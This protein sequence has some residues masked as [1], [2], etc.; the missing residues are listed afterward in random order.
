MAR[1]QSLGLCSREDAR[2][3]HHAACKTALVDILTDMSVADGHAAQL[4]NWVWRHLMGPPAV[5]SGEGKGGD[6]R[7]PIEE[8]VIQVLT[9]LYL[10]VAI[11]SREGQT[12]YSRW[13]ER[14]VLQPLRPAN[15]KVV[16]KALAFVC[17]AIASLDNDQ[18]VYGRVFLDGLPAS[19]RR[20]VATRHVE[21]AR[22]CGV[23][24]RGVFGLEPGQRLLNTDLFA[25]AR[26]VLAT[27][28]KQMLQDL[29]GKALTVGLD[30]GDGNVVVEW[31]GAGGV[32]H[33]AKIPELSL[34]SPEGTVRVAALR[35]IIQR[36]GPAARDFRSLLR[37]TA[38]RELSEDEVSAIFHENANGVAAF[39]THMKKAV[40]L[41][42]SIDV[43]DL[44]PQ[45]LSYFENFAGP[46][47]VME[48]PDVYFRD[49]LVPH[50]KVLLERNLRAGLDICCLGALR[51]DLTPGQWL[52]S[53]GDDAVWEALSSVDAEENPFSLLAALDI[54]MYRQ[55][56]SRFQGFAGEAVERLSEDGFRSRD[57]TDVYR[58]LQVVAD[59]VFNRINLLDSGSIRPGYWK[60]M[61][62]LM[63]ASVIVR[64]VIA[65]SSSMDIDAFEQWLQGATTAV[66]YFAGVV[67]ARTQPMLFFGR[68]T[69]YSLHS[70]ILGRLVALKSRHEKQGRALPRSESLEGALT[71][72]ND[73]EELLTLYFPGPLEGHQR[74]TE[75]FTAGAGIR[76]PDEGSGD[77]KRFLQDLAIVSHVFALDEAELNLAR[78]AV[79]M[80]AENYDAD[81]VET[82]TCLESASLV[83][84]ANRDVALADAIAD[85]MAAVVPRIDIEKDCPVTVAILLQAAAARGTPDEWC[86]WL[87]ERLARIASCLPLQPAESLHVY[88]S[89]L[90]ELRTVLPIHSWFQIRA[91]SIAAS[92][93]R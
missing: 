73:R 81:L 89:I 91:S 90:D 59:F 58:L 7:D 20:L 46:G 92:G 67:D 74:P 26:Q 37:E 42:P 49:V 39:Q 4:C 15:M 71:R 48:D 18:E 11:E 1:L 45:S 35:D 38:S 51:D 65:T 21:F 44:I 47:P 12:R 33:R 84:A 34:F 57:G 69:G 8:W 79:K 55:G 17:E 76:P 2:L 43:H 10:P 68:M 63:H 19:I 53:F 13:M 27:G 36:L 3:R 54:A 93:A 60:R 75:H 88:G 9:Y 87:E 77:L 41:G 86:R 24:T 6:G 78:A 5:A 80:M 82:I 64:D 61:G 22:R 52:A 30:A 32:G 72:S 23:E 66:G 83:A 25:A 70:E 56:D 62:A 31:L 50:R 14:T 16:E 29:A 28:Q 40:S 85:A